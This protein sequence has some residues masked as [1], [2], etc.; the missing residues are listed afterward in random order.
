[1]IKVNIAEAKS[2]L[3]EIRPVA[4]SPAELRPVGIDRGMVLPQSFF[5]PLPEGLLNGGAVNTLMGKFA[6]LRPG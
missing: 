1:M 6:N 3:A 5:E 4:Q 2:H